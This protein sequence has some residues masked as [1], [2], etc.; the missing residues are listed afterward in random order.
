MS[1]ELNVNGPGDPFVMD[2]ATLSADFGPGRLDAYGEVLQAIL[3]R[4]R[5]LSILPESAEQ[6]W[7]IIDQVRA[8]W[9][10]G[11]VP[12]EEYPAGAPGPASWTPEHEVPGASALPPART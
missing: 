12:L 3:D 11:R 5:T 4:D 2:R 10:A 7:R 6:S 8:G 9:K 1:L